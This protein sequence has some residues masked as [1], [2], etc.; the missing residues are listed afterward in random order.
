MAIK[1]SLRK[2]KEAANYGLNQ[3]ES[4]KNHNE[5]TT[6]M[7][8]LSVPSESLNSEHDTPEIHPTI[9]IHKNG[10]SSTN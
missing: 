5:Q 10:P 1:F 6:L 8:N 7:G 3:S 9:L 2:E 4:E